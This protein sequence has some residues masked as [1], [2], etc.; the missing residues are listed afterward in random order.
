MKKTI[1]S[2]TLLCAAF[3]VGAQELSWFP[4]S[5]VRLLEGPF[6]EAQQTD[7]RYIMSMEPDRLLAPFLREAGLTPKAESYTNWENSGLDGHIGGHYIAALAMLWASSGDDAVKQRLDYM[8]AELRRAQIASGDGFIGGT[9][10]SRELWSQIR[11]GDIRANGFGLNDK[12]VPLYNIHKTYAGLRDAWFHAGSEL[13][14]TMLVEFTDWM[15]NVTAGLS[16]AQMQDMLRSEHGGLAE[17]FADVAAI[18]GD[19]K[20]LT[21]AR[22]F[23][24]RTL[25]D[26]LIAGEDKLTGMHANTQIPKVIGFE[27][28]AR[29][30][31]DDAGWGRSA[32]WDRAAR[33]FWEKVVDD[34]SVAIGGNSVR[35][36][37]H[38]SDDYSAMLEDVQG[39]ETC[40]TFNM[41]RLTKMLFETTPTGRLADYYERALYNHILASQHPDDGGFVYFTPMR[42]GHYR[43][44]S[45]PETSMWCCVGSGLENH[46]KYGEF[47]YAYGDDELYVNLFIPSRVEWRERGVTLSQQTVFPDQERVNLTVEKSSRRPFALKLRYP[48]WARG[49]KVSVN[50]REQKIDATAGE[51]ITIERRWRAGDEITLEVAMEV[52]MVQIPDETDHWAFMYGPIV[53]AT[54]MGSDDLEGLRADAGRMSH[55][56]RGRRTP[57]EEIAAMDVSPESPSAALKKNN[58]PRL[59]FTLADGREF[60]PFFRLHD[61]RYAIYLPN[62]KN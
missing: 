21:L 11:R 51:Y 13:A 58:S 20:Y 32:E 14:R 50:G 40:N 10:G 12:W 44:Y 42:A 34:R 33:F 23:S 52:T 3:T 37:F 9:P 7:A 18:T 5:D 60:I 59:A 8:L 54:P 16:D 39:P 29:L 38:P 25:L 45:Q 43:V 28:I 53:L 4:L 41:L 19:A 49:V 56:A 62:K 2:L 17:T 26:P 46:T 24:H 36:H 15:A 47:I 48:G 6:L 27:R 22:R 57:T 1:I 55:V 61:A 30:S 35:E 31:K